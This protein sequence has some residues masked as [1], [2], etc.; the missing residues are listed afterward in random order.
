VAKGT[1][2]VALKKVSE[3]KKTSVTFTTNPC[4]TKK[5][6]SSICFNKDCVL[7]KKATCRGSEGCPGYKGRP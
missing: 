1:A 5:E 3:K 7:R 2:G 6:T 4:D